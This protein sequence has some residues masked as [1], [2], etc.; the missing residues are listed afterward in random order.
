MRIRINN[1]E[2][3]SIIN[4][5]KYEIVKWENNSYYNKKQE[6]IDKGYIEEDGFLK[7]DGSNIQ[8]S[9]FHKKETCY[10]IAW[11]EK[12]SESQLKFTSVGVRP[13]ELKKSEIK[14]VSKVWKIAN[15]MIKK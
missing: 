14:E 9:I 5:F 8:E 7:K 4:S 15:K 12:D 13:I 3:R 6:Y 2:A 10:V 11:L 1:I